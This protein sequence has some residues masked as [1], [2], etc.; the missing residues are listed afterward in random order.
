M[1][2]SRRR[3]VQSALLAGAS[4]IVAAPALARVFYWGTLAITDA[5]APPTAP[6][7]TV[8]KVYMIIENR[9]IDSERLLSVKTPVAQTAH[10]VDDD[11]QSGVVEQ[12]AYLEVRP[13]RPVTLRP[14]R[15]H[16]ELEGLAKP[17]VKGTTFPLTLVFAFA[18]PVEVPVEIDDR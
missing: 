6:R 3:V 18:G 13:R 5:W 8:A 14:G 4:L 1:N 16:V 9:G 10:F 2:L 7:A 11:P 17:L 15:V 12:V